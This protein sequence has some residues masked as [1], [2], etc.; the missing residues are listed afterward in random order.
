MIKAVIFDMDGTIID[1]EPIYEKVNQEIYEKY[2]FNLTQEDYDRH[3]GANL[4]DIWEDI[5]DR[6]QVKD[7]FSHYKIEDFMEDHIHESYQG[8]AE[9]EE[10]EL[11]PGV[12]EWFDFLKDHGYKMI[13]AS[14]SY[15]PVIE[16]IYQRFELEQYMEGYID[17]NA[18]ENGKPA[19]DIFLKAAEK[20]GVKAEECLVIEDTEHGVNGAQRAGAKVVGFNRAQDESQDLSNADLVIE[21]FNQENLQKILK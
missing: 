11:M 6:Y 16:H 4:K 14:S 13:I 19:P 8:L 5:L 1:S 12:K 2:G 21:E 3:M 20:L 15:E 9:A 17:G 7:E 18:I 10:L